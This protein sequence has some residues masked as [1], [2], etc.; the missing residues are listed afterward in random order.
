MFFEHTPVLLDA[1]L[2]GLAVRVGGTYIDGTVGGGGHAEAILARGAAR[3]LGID[4]DPAALAAARE[5]LQPYAER[6]TFVHGNFADIGT[7]AQAHGFRAADGILL[8]IGVSSHQL[9]SAERGFSFNSDAP[10]DMRMN[11]TGGP[12]AADL[13]NTLPERELADVI[14]R[15]GEERASR[16][17]ARLIVERRRAAP[18]ERTTELAELVTRALGGQS[19]RIHPATRTFQALRIAVND[20]LDVLERAL[21]AAANLLAV[22]G[23][24]A[25]IT[26]HSLEDRIVKHFFRRAA[27]R[28]QPADDNMPRLAL[29]NRKPIVAD[30]EEARRNRRSRTAKLRVAERVLADDHA[31]LYE[32]GA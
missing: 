4:Q 7:L 5:R 24:F 26:F 20:E 25:V 17:I 30:R 9:D 29:I 21:P 11:Q 23:R 10:L 19:G 18:I 6:V 13:V 3:L 31:T 27:G 1:T 2:D 28:E 32:K 14:Y 8:D 15:Y 22:G 16:R 12:T